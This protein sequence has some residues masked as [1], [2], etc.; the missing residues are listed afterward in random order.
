MEEQYGILRDGVGKYCPKLLGMFPETP[1]R[2]IAQTR[3]NI[4]AMQV[5]VSQAIQFM[6]LKVAQASTRSRSR[7]I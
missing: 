5:Y 3:S 6:Q 7:S 4:L 1:G 2:D